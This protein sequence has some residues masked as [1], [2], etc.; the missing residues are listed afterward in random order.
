MICLNTS[1]RSPC[2]YIHTYL[3]LIYAH[4]QTCSCILSLSLSSPMHPIKTGSFSTFLP[5]PSPPLIWQ[6]LCNLRLKWLFLKM[7]WA[8]GS[9]DFP[10]ITVP[11][12][13]HKALSTFLTLLIT[14]FQ[15]LWH[16]LSFTDALCKQMCAWAKKERKSK[17]EK[18]LTIVQATCI[19]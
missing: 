2:I 15:L 12:Y 13:H 3:Q 14:L 17:R 19:H 9:W 6:S 8:I 7:P 5:P 11:H 18:C 4:M 16:I 1:N 10:L